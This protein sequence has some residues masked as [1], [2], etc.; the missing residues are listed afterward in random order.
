MASGLFIVEGPGTQ[1]LHNPKGPSTKLSYI[2][3]SSNLHNYYPKPKY[4]ITGSFGSLG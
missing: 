1:G 4:L 2:L 3:K